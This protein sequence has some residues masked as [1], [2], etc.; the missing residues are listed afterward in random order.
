MEEYLQKVLE[1]IRCKQA[2][3]MVEEE[4]RGHLE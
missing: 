1:Q 2:R 3:K 4:L